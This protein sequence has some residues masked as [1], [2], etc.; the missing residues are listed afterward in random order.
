MRQLE[1]SWKKMK[2]FP[3][4]QMLLEIRDRECLICKDE[5]GEVLKRDLL[6]FSGSG[7]SWG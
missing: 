6:D 1:I 4:T 7:C 3:R 5:V 2:F